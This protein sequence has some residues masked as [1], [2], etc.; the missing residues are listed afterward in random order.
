MKFTCYAKKNLQEK[1]QKLLLEI[2][3][4][5]NLLK[6]ST[7]NIDRLY[8]QNVVNLNQFRRDVA[9]ILDDWVQ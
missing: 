6:K 8:S 5:Q 1:V 2:T 4:N 9:A 3:C 7:H